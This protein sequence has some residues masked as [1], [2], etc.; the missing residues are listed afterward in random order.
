[1][2]RILLPLLLALVLA[3]AALWWFSRPLPILTV[4]TW[5]GAYGRAQA[6]AQMHPF[7][8]AAHVDV[9]PAQY[10]GGL[11]ELARAV[12]SKTYTGDV[13]DLGLPDAVKAC[14]QGL[15]E[16][17]DPA[18]LP[19]AADGTPAARDFVPG[20]I[21][22]CWVGEVL[23]A[24]VIVA[25]P[26]TNA[27]TLADFFD[28]AKFPGRRALRRGAKY[29]L[30]MALL[31]DGVAPGDVYKTLSTDDGVARAL[32]KLDS[33]RGAVI[34]LDRPGDGLAMVQDGRAVMASALNGD[35][36]AVP[37]EA[38]R[39]IWDHQLYEM[40]VLAIPRGNPNLKRAMDYVGFATGSSALAGLASWV[41][42]GPARRSSLALVSA[43]PDTKQAMTPHLP[44]LP[45]HFTTAFAVDDAWWLA[46][47]DAMA[48]RWL[49]FEDGAH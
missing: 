34:W 26:G 11:D 13:I 39:V 17:I 4:I 44:S 30:E 35:V 40:D 33:I 36:F 27:Q 19:A 21:G 45:A 42:Y 10:D 43:N 5:P 18:A 47:G 20:A 48:A 22:P 7:G 1:M 2:R 14:R 24:Q 46:H 32:A 3:V 15:L 29:N 25:A 38:P 16:H 41:P 9:R 12:T 37:G 49:A 6:S 8:A 31:A 28:L 23:Y